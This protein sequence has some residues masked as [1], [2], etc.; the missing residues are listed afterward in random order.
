MVTRY[1]LSKQKL[2][3]AH[4]TPP[5]L[6]RFVAGRLIH[7]LGDIRKKHIQ[8]LDPSCGEGELLLAF[9][10]HAR[11][12]GIKNYSL[13]GIEE[14]ADALELA[15]SRLRSADCKVDWLNGDF[16]QMGKM[17]NTLWSAGVN[18]DKVD[19]IIANPP[20]VRTQILGAGR[21]QQLAKEYG[22]SGR[23]DLY[24]AFLV[25][26]TNQL[27]QGGFMSVITSNRF[28]STKGGASVRAFLSKSYDV[29]EVFDLGDTKLFGAAV[30][31]AV[32]LGR[33]KNENTR[34]G[35]EAFSKARFVRIY[36]EDDETNKD[37]GKL[38]QVASVYDIL[39]APQTQKYALETDVYSVATGT[40][41]MSPKST[42]LWRLL[43]TREKRWLDQTENNTFCR[44]AE[45]AKVRVGIKT[46]ADKVF[47]HSD[48]DNLPES[49]RPEKALL[50]PLLSHD[51]VARWQK[52]SGIHTLKKV[53]YT[54][55]IRNGRTRAISLDEY[56]RAAKY[57]ELHRKQLESRKYLIN[58]GR[59]WYEIW[60]PQNPLDWSIPKLVYPDISPEPKFLFDRS[61][62]II[63]GNCYWITL[64]GAVDP[65]VLFIILGVANSKFMKL[66][67]DLA[68]QNR[69]YAGRRRYLTQYVGLYP[70]PRFDNEISKEIAG[71]AK[72]LSSEQLPREKQ[73]CIEEDIDSLVYS[74]FEVS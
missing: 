48:W 67:H 17:Q 51:N 74:A 52:S 58:A 55:E 71:L 2:T 26:M 31:P 33:K 68:F 66:Y 49:I 40:L 61:G 5:E 7:H 36:K 45:V 30:L 14:D 59:K 34:S 15:K 64:K 11:A 28:L 9:Y 73:K 1:K 16:L 12:V 20:Y 27:A 62:C 38:V 60:V 43:T 53:L 8:V 18:F 47:I 63:D 57:F 22:L 25:A 29:L 56:P 19:V 42:E 69:L 70:L 37:A 65:N 23:V 21:A 13:V 32:F 72:K 54:H 39:S 44:I 46:T 3:G 35:Y 41:E 50:R 4:F 6:A 10:K 24:H